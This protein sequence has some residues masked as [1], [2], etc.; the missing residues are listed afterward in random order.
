MELTRFRVREAGADI[1][2]REFGVFVNDLI[3]RHT[4]R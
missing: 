2:A 3:G 4:Q 1:V